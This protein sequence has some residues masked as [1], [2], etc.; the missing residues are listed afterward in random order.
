MNFKT[1]VFSFL[2]LILAIGIG[3]FYNNDKSALAQTGSGDLSGYGWSSNIG[4]V[5]FSGPL[6]GVT[7]DSSGNFSGYAWSSNVGWLNMSGVKMTAGKLTG[8]GQFTASGGGWDG[9]VSFSG[10]ATDGSP[11]G[12]NVASDG[13]F[14]GYAWG[15]EVVGWLDMS[16]V[17]ADIVVPPECT[18]DVDC[19][20]GD[21]DYI[22]NPA[23]ECSNPPEGG[24]LS[25]SCSVDPE[26]VVLS[27]GE[28]AN[29]DVS[30]SVSGGVSPYTYN[31]PGTHTG[32]GANVVYIVNSNSSGSF[33]VTVTDN[34]GNS[35]S[36]TCSVLITSD[37]VVPGDAFN[38]EIQGTNRFRVINPPN[39]NS[40]ESTAVTILPTIGAEIGS[41]SLNDDIL[42]TLSSVDSPEPQIENWPTSITSGTSFTINVTF[43]DKPRNA[44]GG[45]LY[46]ADNKSIPLTISASTGQT[47]SLPTRLQYFDPTIVQE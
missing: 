38:F 19:Q 12:V 8:F 10:T 9:K 29:I 25:V 44:N 28:T 34:N 27:N 21:P 31:W 23:D 1:I 11:Y 14:S 45:N 37:E 39:T 30:A 35:D 18:P 32:S 41:I 13:S 26:T 42:N 24:G 43:H 22:P 7:I 15:D 20:C 2:V 16:R 36:G 6:Y 33:T 4:W 3:F 17:T 47:F 5:S 46:N 40:Y